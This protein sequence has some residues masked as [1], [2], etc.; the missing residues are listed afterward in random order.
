MAM[1]RLGYL[2]VKKET[3]RAV[4]VKPTNFI[5]FKEGS[6]SYEQEIIANNPIQNVRWNAIT[7]VPGK[8]GTDGEYSIDADVREMGFFL[9][10]AMGTYGITSL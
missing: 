8:I 9:F 2:A 7:A 3:T 1:T 10:G 5:R 4:A 6:I